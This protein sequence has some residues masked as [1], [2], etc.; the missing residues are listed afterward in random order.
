MIQLDLFQPLPLVSRWAGDG[1]F[2]SE[3]W[4]DNGDGTAIRRFFD[5]V[6]W[7]QTN[8]APCERCGHWHP[9]D[10]DWGHGDHCTGTIQRA[11]R[12]SLGAGWADHLGI[13]RE[14]RP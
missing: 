12:C 11:Y 5:G 3:V 13:P 4:R 14:Q 6:G 2:P 1:P 8:A 9:L 7:C 10:Y